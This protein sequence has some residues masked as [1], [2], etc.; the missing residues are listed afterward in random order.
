MRADLT[1]L[2][3]PMIRFGPGRRGGALILLRERRCPPPPPG[4][5]LVEPILRAE[6]R[7]QLGLLA[8]SPASF[9]ERLVAG[10]PRGDPSARHRR[11]HRQA[12][13]GDASSRDADLSR[14]PALGRA[15]VTIA[16]QSRT[17][18]STSAASTDC[19]SCPCRRASARPQPQPLRRAGRPGRRRR[20]PPGSGW[21]NRVVSL[22]PKA[23]GHLAGLA[24]AVGGGLPL[25]VAGGAAD[26]AAG[27]LRA[28]RPSQR[29]RARSGRHDA[30]QDGQ[31][32]RAGFGARAGVAGQLL[33]A[34]DGP[35]I[36]ALETGAWDTRGVGAAGGTA[37]ATRTGRTGAETGLRA[38]RSGV[39]GS[40]GCGPGCHRT[41]CSRT[42]RMSRSHLGWMPV[43]ST[44]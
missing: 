39:A 8:T 17:A 9:R 26:A 37:V 23:P 31:H 24:L 41:G 20:A 6:A 16:G 11:C 25:L 10:H 3:A 19:T 42:R 43:S 34:V 7:A 33:A 35:R 2:T 29:R 21:L 14:Q 18:C 27:S 4:S 44:A 28:Y 12:A 30:A 1:S 32:R 40:A 22:L 13:G 38:A 15:G 36:A 5:P